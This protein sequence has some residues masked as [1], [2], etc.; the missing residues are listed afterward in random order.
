MTIGLAALLL[1]STNPC[2]AFP[3]TQRIDEGSSPTPSNGKED[4]L[5][6]GNPNLYGLGIRSSVYIITFA[7]ALASIFKQRTAIELSKIAGLFHFAIFVALLRE[8]ITNSEQL[9]AVEA[10]VACLVCLS[11]LAW[12][13]FG[14]PAG[15]DNHYSPNYLEKKTLP[16][17]VF[18]LRQLTVLGVGVYQA[19]FWFLGVNQ[20]QRL[21]CGTGTET[22]FLARVDMYGPFGMFAKIWSVLVIIGWQSTSPSGFSTASSS[23]AGYRQFLNSY[24]QGFS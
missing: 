13:S 21:P 19:W 9:Y 2:C 23:S 14:D 6:C 20:L 22:F 10:M 15:R 24:W 17:L 12:A 3:T 4:C 7:T 1:L 8:T 11:P 18:L 16:S 5:F